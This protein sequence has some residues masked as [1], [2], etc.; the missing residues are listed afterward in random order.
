MKL[1]WVRGADILPETAELAVLLHIS[2]TFIDTTEREKIS[3]GRVGK[4]RCGT[5][6]EIS[7]FHQDVGFSHQSQNPRSEQETDDPD[8]PPASCFS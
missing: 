4:H 5:K 2:Q 8:Y 1:I 7:T 6:Q 3:Q